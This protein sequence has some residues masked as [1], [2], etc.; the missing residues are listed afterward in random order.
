MRMHFFCM[1]M[2]RHARAQVG[3]AV[4]QQLPTCYCQIISCSMLDTS[5]CACTRFEA[6]HL[7]GAKSLLGFSQESAASPF[8][9]AR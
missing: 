5:T 3:E 7:V 1:S 4:L 9:T 8:L 6:P 2:R